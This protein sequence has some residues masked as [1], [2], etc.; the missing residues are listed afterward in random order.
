MLIHKIQ[1]TNST[2]I[3][4]WLNDLGKVQGVLNSFNGTQI[5]NYSAAIKGLNLNQAQLLLTTQRLDSERSK[6]ILIEAGLLASENSIQAE[7]LE[8]TLIRAGLNNEERTAILN[9]LGLISAES[10]EATV[11]GTCTKAD[12]EAVLAQ[13]LKNAEDAEGIIKTLGLAGANATTTA[14]FG[15]LT[16]SI[17][18]NIKAMAAWMISN[19]IGWIILGVG[20]VFGLVKGI[21]ALTESTEEAADA[22]T[23]AKEKYTEIESEIDSL[24]NKIKENKK[25]IEETNGNAQYD[26]YRKRLEAENKELERQIELERIK[27]QEAKSESDRKATKLLTSEKYEYDK[28]YDVN[29]TGAGYTTT[30]Q[31]GD[32]YTATDWYLKQA[33]S[34]GVISD[35]LKDNID[36]I[37]EQRE[38]LDLLNPESKKLYDNLGLLIDRYV[39]LY[40]NI[41]LTSD[42]SSDLSDATN[43]INLSLDAYK[44]AS[45]GI[46]SLATAFKE[47]T[48]DEY[49]SLET[50]SK[51]KEAVGDSISN[52]DAYEQKLLSVK[53]GTA[54]YNQLM[55]ELTYATLEKQLGGVNALAQADEKYVAQLLREN[56]VLNANEVAHNAVER[57]KAK[58]LAQ[59]NANNQES[60]KTVESLIQEANSAGISTNAYLE[61]T[62]KEILF[63]NNKLDTSDKC[64]QIL[65]IASAAGVAST[66]Y[67]T[68]SSQIDAWSSK[69][70]LGSGTRTQTATDLGMTV[71]NEKNRGKDGK[72]KGNLYVASDGSE[73]EDYK[74]AMYYQESLNNVQKISDAYSNVNFV[75]PDYSGI[76]TGNK[77]DTKET[78]DWIETKVKRL[79]RTITNFGKTVS[80]TWESWTNRNS[81]LKSQISAVTSEINLQQQ[82]A[83]KYLSLANGVS[84]SG[85][86][87]ELV[88]NGSLNISTISDENTINAIK[89]YQEYYNA[90]LD[91][92]DA[93]QDAQDELA[94]LVREDFDLIAKQFDSEISLVEAN[95]SNL[96]AYIDQTEMKGNLVSKNYYSA[97]YAQEEKNLGLLRQKYEQLSN[98]LSNGTIAQGSEEFNNMTTEIKEV[99]KAIIESNTALEEY[100]KTMRD[101]DWEVFD[102]IEE[103]IG[104]VTEESEFLIDLLSNSKLFNDDGSTTSQGQATLG[105]HVANMRV[106]ESQIKD[107]ANEIARL[108]AQFAN[109]SLDKNYLERRQ[110]LLE[111]QHESI[112]AMKSEEQSIRDL[113]SD[114]Y[115]PAQVSCARF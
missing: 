89:K 61:L 52:W 112:L 50:I 91:C 7:L 12:L 90:Y 72:G 99:S 60:V 73:F 98:K 78:F 2:N 69:D 74:D 49:V 76:E 105:L 38:N 15:L 115:A 53:K 47:L 13:K 10:T 8:T 96:E 24:N 26:G 46:S 86:Y 33:E 19:P 114:G 64:K 16:K 94:S 39:A 71:I 88:R 36:I 110:E 103:K 23:E 63:N 31:K 68:L 27:A 37:K 106:Y 41:K 42:E 95:I 43:K 25:L 22:A 5:T 113:W 17:W 75:L 59:S 70:L 28:K 62:A 20:A 11:Q 93:K 109:D 79:Q 101:L 34:T 9:Q 54:E 57:A 44:K 14:S 45:E 1:I 80:A 58:E 111:L 21:D 32:I 18:A 6:E 77:K 104:N 48:D 108:D 100:Q 84:L 82:A 51:I 97:M 83:D 67:S 29:A 3:K 30:S 40:P 85:T 35:T 56:G 66:A 55:R 87:K 92:L 65:A 107:Y 81:A 4:T 102:I